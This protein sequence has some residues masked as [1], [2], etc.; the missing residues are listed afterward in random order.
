MK[1]SVKTRARWNPI[2]LHW[3]LFSCNARLKFPLPRRWCKNSK[4][5]HV[6]RFQLIPKINFFFILCVY[7]TNIILI[8]FYENLNIKLKK[9]SQKCIYQYKR[10][11]CVK[12]INI[13]LYIDSHYIKRT[14]WMFLIRMSF[15]CI[16]ETVVYSYTLV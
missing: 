5:R 12:Y 10:V 4:R 9:I 7:N 3:T 14:N 2:T 8:F 13:K 15:T 16:H 1:S 11:I 6:C